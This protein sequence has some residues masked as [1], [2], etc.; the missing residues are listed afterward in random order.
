MNAM[1][2]NRLIRE[3]AYV[4]GKTIAEVEGMT[5]ME[6]SLWLYRGRA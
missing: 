3:L 2:W 5:L 4:S 1:K 6:A